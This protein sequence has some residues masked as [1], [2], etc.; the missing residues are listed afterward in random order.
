MLTAEVG[1]GQEV[2]DLEAGSVLAVEA[3]IQAGEGPKALEEEKG[4]EIEDLA[5]ETELVDLEAG[6]EDPVAGVEDPPVGI[7]S[8][9]VEI[10]NTE[11]I[12]DPEVESLEVLVTEIDLEVGVLQF[13]TIATNQV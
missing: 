3:S 7:E 6:T 12:N 8:R 2:E 11:A 9:I 13:Q 10:G 5:A 1:K 4:V